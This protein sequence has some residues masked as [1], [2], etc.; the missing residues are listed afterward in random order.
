[1]KST[2]SGSG[3]RRVLAMASAPRSATR[4]RRISASISFL[5]FSIRVI[6]LVGLEPLLERRHLAAK[7]LTLGFHKLVDHAV[8]VEVSQRA[9][10]VI[11]ATDRAAGL[12]AGEPGNRLAGQRSHHGVVAVHER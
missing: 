3:L 8:E 9:V 2:S 1:M 12:H 11:R 4:R 7:L 6:E 5:N 10:Q